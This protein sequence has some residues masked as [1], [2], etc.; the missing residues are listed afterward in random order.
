MKKVKCFIIDDDPVA[1]RSIELILRRI[2]GV[3]IVGMF[4]ESVKATYEIVVRKPDVIFLDIN[5]PGLDGFE[6]LE[7]LDSPPKIVIVSG[8]ERNLPPE[9]EKYICDY[10]V[11]PVTGKD[12]ILEAL[13]KADLGMTP[14]AVR[15]ILLCEEDEAFSSM[16]SYKLRKDYDWNITCTRYGDEAM[17]LLDKNTYDVVI[18]STDLINHSGFDLLRHVREILKKESPFIMMSHDNTKRREALALHVT[19]Y[20]TKPFGP[21]EISRRVSEVLAVAY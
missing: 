11:K 17:A 20:L 9:L 13:A 10:I 5:M 16:I 14:A 15:N 4:T 21:G 12:R 19:D 18:S 1:V 3:E 2:E 8:N 6:L 7:T